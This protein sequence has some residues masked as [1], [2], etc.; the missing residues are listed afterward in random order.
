MVGTPVVTAP[1][2]IFLVGE[3]AILEGGAAVLAA[4]NRYAVA[5]FVPGMDPASKVVAEA[6]KRATAET[7][8]AGSALPLGSV[9]VNSEDFM[10]GNRKIG[11]G[12]SAATAVAALEPSPIF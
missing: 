6:V 7:G 4:V 10:Q 2:K 12:S 11:L 1:G 8:E 9:L 5:Q 3:Y